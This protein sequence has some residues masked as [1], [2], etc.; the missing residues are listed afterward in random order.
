VLNQHLLDR[1]HGERRIN[2]LLHQPHEPIE[3]LLKRAIGLAL[4]V[5]N[6]QNTFSQ[7][8][9]GVLEFFYSVFPLLDVGLVVFEETA[10]ALLGV[11][12]T[13]NKVIKRSPPVPLQNG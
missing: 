4:L 9:D 7:R 13:L 8:W 12:G 10:N 1:F 6:L 2:A 11:A 3:G 5:E